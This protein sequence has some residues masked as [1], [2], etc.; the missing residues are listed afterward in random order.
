MTCPCTAVGGTPHGETG[1]DMDR[2][3]PQPR[4][5]RR[6]RG[7]SRWWVRTRSEK[8]ALFLETTTL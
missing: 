4:G 1:T 5:E 6:Y 2:K 8:L 3:K 7:K